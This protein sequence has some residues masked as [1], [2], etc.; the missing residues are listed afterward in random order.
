MNNAS[1]NIGIAVILSTGSNP[2]FVY[3]I[4]DSPVATSTPVFL[5]NQHIVDISFCF[6]ISIIMESHPTSAM[7]MKNEHDVSSVTSDFFPMINVGAY[8][9]SI[10]DINAAMD[11]YDLLY[12][13]IGLSDITAYIGLNIHG[14]ETMDHAMAFSAG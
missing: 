1:M 12:P 8:A 11:M 9:N 7:H 14:T 13:N 3:A 2:I 5:E 4:P 6:D 10:P